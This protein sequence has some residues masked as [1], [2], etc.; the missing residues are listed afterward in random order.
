MPSNDFFNS[1]ERN[2]AVIR[3]QGRFKTNADAA[4]DDIE[5]E[6]FT[7]ALA[8]TGVFTVTFDTFYDAILCAEAAL[9][10]AAT[11]EHRVR[12]TG[13]TAG[14]ATAN[15]TLEIS[16][17]LLDTGAYV[18]DETSDDDWVH[19]EVVAQNAGRA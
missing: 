3:L 14:S 5:G 13:F 15:A 6:G 18:A 19:F 4:P 11:S 9:E 12:V 16:E 10:A 2:P 1:V 17:V 7:V 8:A